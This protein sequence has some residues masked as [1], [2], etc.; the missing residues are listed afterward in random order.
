MNNRGT[1]IAR[2]PKMNKTNEKNIKSNSHDQIFYL[3]ILFDR[4][5]YFVQLYRI[6]RTNS[7]LIQFN[8][9]E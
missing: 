9:I 5:K 4:N 1:V 6:T 3:N 7:N 2:D 8:P